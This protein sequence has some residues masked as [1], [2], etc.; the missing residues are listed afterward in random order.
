M[1]VQFLKYEL[2]ADLEKPDAL[3]PE[4]WVARAREVKTVDLHFFT[5]DTRFNER[6]TR[7]IA[8]LNPATHK[9]IKHWAKH[10]LPGYTE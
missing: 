2:C 3:D 9:R 1:L 7:G 5:N 4:D 8:A 6:L 10:H